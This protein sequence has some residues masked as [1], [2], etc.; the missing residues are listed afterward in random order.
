MPFP[1]IDTSTRKDK[2]YMVK[3]NGKT[4]HFGASGYSDFIH[5]KDEKR[6]ERYI[7]RHQKRENWN[8]PTTAGFWSRWILWNKPTLQESLL[9]VKKRFP[10][11]NAKSSGFRN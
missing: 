6:K 3:V 8:D 4:I 10:N 11:I 5:N 7:A 1:V 9:D 2:K